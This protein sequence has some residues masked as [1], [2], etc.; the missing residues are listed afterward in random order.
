MPAAA[1]A[2]ALRLPPLPPDLLLPPAAEM[3]DTIGGADAPKRPPV[4]PALPPLAADDNTDP[5]P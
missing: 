5:S 1:L 4:P 3:E 2:A